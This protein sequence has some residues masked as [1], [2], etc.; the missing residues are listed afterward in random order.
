[1]CISILLVK[2]ERYIIG[3]DE[4][5]RGPLAGPVA[6]GMVMLPDSFEPINYGLTAGLGEL[7]DSKKLTELAR[8]R[9]F[10]ELQKLR[11][12]GELDYRVALIGNA[13]IDRDGINQAIKVG[14]KRLLIGIDTNGVKVFLD[15]GLKAPE[16]FDQETIIKGDE[17]VAA[18][19][20]A[21]IAAKVTR[22]HKM[23][24]WDKKFPLYGFAQHKGYGTRLHQERIQQHGLCSIH[25]VTF[26][27]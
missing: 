12:K 23:S 4:A 20:L 14:I 26:I 2:K 21:S 25:R 18:I 7:R 24:F 1:M 15:G 16:Y 27:K 8:E 6:V 5:G 13:T 19:S 10:K 22:D 17:K 3:I 11:K 9:W